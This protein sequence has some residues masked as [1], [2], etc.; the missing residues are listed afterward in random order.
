MIT[1]FDCLSTFL[2]SRDV[3]EHYKSHL[4][5]NV[6][7]FKCIECNK[8]YSQLNSLISHMKRK[9]V[10]SDQ[11]VE[12][13]NENIVHFSKPL[14]FTLT[15]NN[16]E[17][18]QLKTVLCN[19][20]GT[21]F[22]DFQNL[23]NHMK[24][25]HNV[26]M[27]FQN[28]ECNNTSSNEENV[29]QILLNFE[30][31]LLSHSLI[32]YSDDSLSRKNV[33]K[34][35]EL[36]LTFI[37]SLF[38]DIEKYLPKQLFSEEINTLIEY[39]KTYKIPSESKFFHELEK[40]GLLIQPYDHI[41]DVKTVFGLEKHKKE[42]FTMKIVPLQK[43]LTKV[44]EINNFLIE[45]VTY[46]DSLLSNKNNEIENIIQ[47]NFW[48]EKLKANGNSENTLLIPISVYFDDFDPLN[49]LAGHAGAY[50][51]GGIYF[52]IACLPP[53]LQSKLDFIFL[54][55]LFFSEDR[56]TYG[57]HRIFKPVIDELNLLYDVGIKIN[58]QHYKSV[59]FITVLVVGDNLGLNSILGFTSGFR[60]NH[61]CRFCYTHRRETLTLT[62]SSINEV[63]TRD[64]FEEAL[65][66][67]N[68]ENTGVY[69]DSP[70]NKIKQFHC[71]NNPSV[72]LMHDILE[73]VAH[74]DIS[75][76]LEF[77]IYGE[78]SLLNLSDFNN[79][80]Q[81]TNLGPNKMLTMIVTE[82]MI[83]SKRFKY[84]AS[85]MILF[86]KNLPFVIG[87]LVPEDC[88]VWKI[89]IL[90]RNILCTV[91]ARSVQPKTHI[92]LKYYIKEHHQL[93]LDIGK[94]LSMAKL[95]HLVHYDDIM[96]KI[97]P[98]IAAWSMRFEGKHE[99]FD[100][101]SDVNNCRKN[102]IH[103]FSLKHQLKMAEMF[104]NRNC[105]LEKFVTGILTQVRKEEIFEL[106]N[107]DIQGDSIFTMTSCVYLGHEL[108]KD[109]AI[110][111]DEEKD[112]E[113]IFGL[114][115]CIFIQ[116]EMYFVIVQELFC[117]GFDEHYCAYRILKTQSFRKIKLDDLIINQ[118]SHVS[119][120]VLGDFFINWE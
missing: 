75:L 117:S 20:C 39:L 58:F 59:K 57:N 16:N 41:I 85:E 27:E 86:I 120:N 74:F 47:T 40:Y 4:F 82:T 65:N 23:I 66:L 79:I 14:K 33:R 3:I 50:Q 104:C 53:H 45:L 63:R 22:I 101:I 64:N 44:F 12:T 10:D 8:T 19:F 107:I 96:M 54:L 84:S 69:N 62:M 100:S 49:A 71:T 118:T 30:N 32:L 102:L 55:A 119:T 108:K 112:S 43:L 91:M 52:Q 92:I 110:K 109:F 116:N 28:N 81:N 61:F 36:I 60:H 21:K 94:Q 51:I 46:M 13:E 106:Y 89:Y 87:H 115:K 42:E 80:L 88:L 6:S 72:D 31:K 68:P 5:E 34:M 83:K 113:P 90:L 98:L 114:I 9:H 77:C 26:S 15:T 25:A 111:Y 67:K 11:T 38:S 35:L 48:A 97:G 99:V 29:K 7:F 73:G 17:L 78:N 76:V 70:F 103:T 24:S 95:H 105:K 93:I 2:T 18:K 56:K 1:C 37:K